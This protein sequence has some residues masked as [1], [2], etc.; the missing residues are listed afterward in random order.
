MLA[1]HVR[2]LAGMLMMAIVLSWS[3]SARTS[4]EA[5]GTGYVY[6]CT[7]PNAKVYHSTP[8]CKGLRKCSGEVKRVEKVS[9][10]R[11]PCKVCF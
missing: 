2:L 3:L 11:R 4:A 9:V 7:G 6:I 8:D 5:A 1:M 10:N